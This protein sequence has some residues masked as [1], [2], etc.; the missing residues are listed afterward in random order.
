[1][2]MPPPTWARMLRSL[3]EEREGTMSSRALRESATNGRATLT[4]ELGELEVHLLR[5]SQT[6]R[7]V[8]Q[9]AL[10]K[11]V[12]GP[13]ALAHCVNHHHIQMYLHDVDALFP[14]HQ[15][16]H[17][18]CEQHAALRVLGD[19]KRS[20]L[21]ESLTKTRASYCIKAD[22]RRGKT[23]TQAQLGELV[24]I[25]KPL[26]F[27]PAATDW[28]ALKHKVKTG[29]GDLVSLLKEAI[30]LDPEELCK[31]TMDGTVS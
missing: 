11:T 18:E 30:G 13:T 20:G 31:E 25:K 10:W 23:L 24:K 28:A 7:R 8:R 26:L 17:G 27:Q 21:A 5:R 4:G 9:L 14:L 1:M 6:L 29:E 12:E 19:A 15:L 2:E 3:N 22:R 16:H